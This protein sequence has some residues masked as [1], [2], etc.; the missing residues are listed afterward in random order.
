MAAGVVNENLVTKQLEEF[1]E[2]G[3][4]EPLLNSGDID[5]RTGLLNALVICHCILQRER[6]SKKQN[7]DKVYDSS[8]RVGVYQKYSL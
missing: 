1:S 5:T 8:G 2:S 7:K 3:T 6:F 4:I